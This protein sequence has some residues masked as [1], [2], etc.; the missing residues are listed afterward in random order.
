MD[1]IN[2]VRI[3]CVQFSKPHLQIETSK[4]IPYNNHINVEKTNI[5]F[6]F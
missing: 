1:K 5:C 3:F 4:S 2:T 6:V